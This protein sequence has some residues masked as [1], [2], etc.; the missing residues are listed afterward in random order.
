MTLI[1]GIKCV[2][3]FL[4]AADTAI[5]DGD[6]VMYHGQKIEYQIGR[7]HRIVIACAGDLSYAQTAARQ[8]RERLLEAE[9]KSD[10]DVT[11]IIRVI[12]TE[13]IDVHVR[14]IYPYWNAKRNPTPEFSLIVGVESR[15]LCAVLSTSGTTVTINDP[16]VFDGDGRSLA[17]DYAESYVRSRLHDSLSL[18]TASAI[19]IVDEIFRIVKRFRNGVGLD[20]RMYAWRT[21]DS[22]LPFFGLSEKEQNIFWQIQENLKAALWSALELDSEPYLNGIKDVPKIYI[23]QLHEATKRAMK[24]DCHFISY[25]SMPRGRELKI[26][27][28]DRR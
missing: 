5:S 9:G 24:Y 16:Y 11:Q 15:G 19:H 17:H 14:H 13:L 3:G 25:T 27:C 18:R 23:E 7:D 20:T 28:L 12:E 8:I 4:I 26:Q 10:L 22:P 21:E 2:D 1:A 6:V